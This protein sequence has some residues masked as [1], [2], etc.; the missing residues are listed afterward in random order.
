MIN[1][2][3]LA[4]ALWHSG[5]LAVTCLLPVRYADLKSAKS[6]RVSSDFLIKAIFGFGNKSIFLPGII[7]TDGASSRNALLSTLG[8][9]QDYCPLYFVHCPFVH[10]F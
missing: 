9:R 4:V 8:L 7:P 1:G 6:A 5:T 10:P 2:L 3:Y